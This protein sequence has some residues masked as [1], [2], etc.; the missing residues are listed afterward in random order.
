MSNVPMIYVN[1]GN[2]SG[3]GGLKREGERLL[4]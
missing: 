3:A 1:I 2:R 4:V